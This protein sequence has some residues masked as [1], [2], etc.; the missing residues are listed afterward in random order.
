MRVPFP[1]HGIIAFFIKE[2]NFFFGI[3][4]FSDKITP[5]SDFYHKLIENKYFIDL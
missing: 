4:S 2:E 5:T 1:A 3:S